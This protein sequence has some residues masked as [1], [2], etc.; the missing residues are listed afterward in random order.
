M[1]TYLYDEAIL[2]KINNWTKDTNIH[3]YGPDETRRLFEVVANETND[4]PIK[5]PLISISR[6][7]GFNILN[8]SKQPLAYNSAKIQANSEKTM[9]LNAVPIEISYQLDVYA[10]YYKE[11]D[12]IMRN[13][14]F[15]IISF[16]QLSIII[17]YYEQNIEHFSNIRISNEISD[18]SSIPE[19]LSIGQFTRLSLLFNIDDAYLFDIRIRDVVRLTDIYVDIKKEENIEHIHVDK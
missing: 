4:S 18:N 10:R 8:T 14:I 12:E 13:L 17:P 11:A 2:N 6:V 3:I 15:N 19:R 9:L 5:L 1:S 7:G 16:P